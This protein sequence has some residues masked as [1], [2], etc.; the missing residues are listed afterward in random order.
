[1]SRSPFPRMKGMAGNRPRTCVNSHV[2]PLNSMAGASS[3]S[4][5]RSGSPSRIQLFAARWMA[6]RAPIESPQRKTRREPLSE[7][8]ALRAAST[9]S[10]RVTTS[11]SS[12]LVPCPGKSGPS[13][14]NPA[15]ASA[16]PTGR[17]SAGEPVRPCRRRHESGP[18]PSANG[19]IGRDMRRA[20][21]ADPRPC[22]KRGQRRP[23]MPGET[24]APPQVQVQL[25][26]DEPT[27]LGM[28]VNMAMINHNETEF[29]ID[30][31]YMQPQAPKAV[32]R[33]RIINS[34]KHM[35]RFLHALQDNVAKY[36]A[37]FGK[38]DVSGPVPHPIGGMP[39]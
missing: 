11:R 30:F 7:R 10:P 1:M 4:A 31:I 32:V 27:A 2:M 35:K 8:N 38:I 24:P 23:T 19:S 33:A 26:I 21:I 5:L 12:G 36:E 16:S 37:Q 28:Y 20:A 9:I 22:Y 34:P 6:N 18:S 17:T 3:A 29:V 25:Q 15:A 14:R 39:H 13:A